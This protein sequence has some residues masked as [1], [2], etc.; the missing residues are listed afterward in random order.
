MVLYVDDIVEVHGTA[1]DTAD[2][3]DLTPGDQHVFHDRAVLHDERH[4]A[5]SHPVCRK[6]ANP[7]SDVFWQVR[8]H[9]DRLETRALLFLYAAW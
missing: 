1:V 9:D 6:R 4:L 2:P 8:G 5:G 3:D 7:L